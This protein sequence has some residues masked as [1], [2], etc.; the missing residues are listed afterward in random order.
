[1]RFVGER[2]ALA[3]A[4]LAF[5]MLQLL[6]S[7]LLVDSP[8]R[9][10][11]IGLGVV[12][13]AAFM[14]VVAGYFW[15]RWFSLGLAFSGLAMAVM[16]AFRGGEVGPAIYLIG[17]THAIVGLGLIGPD[18]A[19]FYDGRRDWRER[20]RMDENAVNRLGK[21]VTRAGA[22]LPYLIVAGLAPKDGAGSMALLALGLGA[23]GL[24]G[25]V[26][27]RTWG[28]LALAGAAGCALAA[29][30]AS[31]PAG[32]ALSAGPGVPVLALAPACAAVLLA[33]AV[34]PFARPL[35]AHLRGH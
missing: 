10:V 21:A 15:A 25:L 3:A 12:Y 23:L 4:V 26:R 16:S 8:F 17:I 11:L 27:L 18:A 28:L 24:V 5:F 2:R 13:G 30:P 29:F 31:A 35:A 20:Y 19:T 9:G 1:M 34:L 7:G 33:A 6:L 32:F 22:S 14:G